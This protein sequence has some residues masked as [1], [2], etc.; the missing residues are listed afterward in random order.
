MMPRHRA[1]QARR[2]DTVR[3]KLDAV[4][5]EAELAAID[6]LTADPFGDGTAWP[7]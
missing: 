4:T 6:P 5:T 7:A 2:R 3:A 1:G